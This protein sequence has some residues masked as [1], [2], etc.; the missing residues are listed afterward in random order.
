MTKKGCTKI[1]NFMTVLMLRYGHISHYY[2]SDYAL[3]SNILI[4][5]TLIPIVLRDYNAAFLCNFDFNLFHMMG[6]V[7]CKYEPVSV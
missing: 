2:N 4:C 5:S 1:I 3:F 6:L 7:I